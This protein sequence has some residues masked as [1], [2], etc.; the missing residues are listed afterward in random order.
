RV[1]AG[2][3]QD[4]LFD[5]RGMR[6]RSAP[7]DRAAEG[8]AAEHAARD[9]ELVQNRDEKRDVVVEGIDAV[10][11]RAGESEAREVVADYAAPGFQRLRP[12][13]PRVERGAGAVQQDD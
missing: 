12:A 5:P 2:V 1:A 10:R 7:G 13:L 6:E 4:E 9:A 11:R 3:H 8:I